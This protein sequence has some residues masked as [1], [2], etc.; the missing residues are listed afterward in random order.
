MREVSIEKCRP[1][2]RVDAA[3]CYDSEKRLLYMFGGLTDQ[4]EMNDFWVFDCSLGIWS[5]LENSS[6]SARGGS[7]MVYDHECSQIFLIGRKPF[8]KS[9]SLKVR[10][11]KHFLKVML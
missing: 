2:P 6:V 5:Q 11:L 7:K 8:G 3:Y 10:T 4:T 1:N 9:E